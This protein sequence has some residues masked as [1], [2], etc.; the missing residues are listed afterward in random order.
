MSDV[1]LTVILDYAQQGGPPFAPAATVTVS[2]CGVF[3]FSVVAP[4]LHSGILDARAGY[5][6]AM[7]GET[8]ERLVS[9]ATLARRQ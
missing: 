5:G 3:R 8:G 1:G 4:C 2:F 9:P 6:A 7:A